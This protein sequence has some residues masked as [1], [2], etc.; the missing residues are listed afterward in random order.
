[1]FE[2]VWEKV[3]VEKGGEGDLKV[4]GLS[5]SR[6]RT[7]P[8]ISWRGRRLFEEKM[9]GG[10]MPIVANLGRSEALEGALA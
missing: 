2:G 1:M 4:G 6:G 9:F 8:V 7:T 3:D 5:T 10:T